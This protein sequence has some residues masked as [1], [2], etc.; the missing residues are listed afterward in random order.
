MWPNSRDLPVTLDTN[1]YPM[2][3]H[4]TQGRRAAC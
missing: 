2:N 1:L 3:I 4:A